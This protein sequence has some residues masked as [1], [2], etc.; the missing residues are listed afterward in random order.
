MTNMTNTKQKS[1]G[2]LRSKVVYG[3]VVQTVDAGGSATVAPYR[4]CH[5][6]VSRVLC[7]PLGKLLGQPEP[8]DREVVFQPKPLAVGHKL[9]NL[10]IVAGNSCYGLPVDP[11]QVPLLLLY[12]G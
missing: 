3:M 6:L 5:P 7:R 2:S 4:F 8:P 9:L 11:G 1:S 10:S 12:Q